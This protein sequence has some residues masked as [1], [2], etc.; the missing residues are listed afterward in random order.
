MASPSFTTTQ[1][2]TP[3]KSDNPR[4]FPQPHDDDFNTVSAT[5]SCPYGHGS[6]Q[7]KGHG[8]CSFKVQA[9]ANSSTTPGIVSSVL[10]EDNQVS[11]E[12]QKRTKFD[13]NVVVMVENNNNNNNSPP[14]QPGQPSTPVQMGIGNEEK[15]SEQEQELEYVNV[16]KT[17]QVSCLKS[18]TTQFGQTEFLN[19]ISA[20]SD[21]A[22]QILGRLVLGWL[23]RLAFPPSGTLTM[24][25]QARPFLCCVFPSLDPPIYVPKATSV[26]VVNSRVLNES[27]HGVSDT[28]RQIVS[29][30]S[31]CGG[32]LMELS[33]I[34]NVGGGVGERVLDEFMGPISEALGEAGLL[35]QNQLLSILESTNPVNHNSMREAANKTFSV[36]K[37]LSIDHRAFSERVRKFISCAA[38]FAKIEDEWKKKGEVVMWL[39]GKIENLYENEKAKFDEIAEIE[40]ETMAAIAASDKGVECIAEEVMQVREKLV[41]MEKEL[42]HRK[43]ENEE[44]KCRAGMIKEDMEEAKKKMEKARA[45]KTVHEERAAAIEALEMARLH[46]RHNH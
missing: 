36:L 40:R 8:A 14:D 45:A 5:F 21:P 35:V 15:E 2:P 9:M 19:Q 13:S 42:R 18:D 25:Q 10:N 41:G 38:E 34:K 32:I 11:F 17:L 22:K 29:R 30:D 44:L 28:Y 26:D 7:L 37:L 43:I 31:E 6:C 3:I 20:D 23:G 1:P 4:R 16:E 39:P 46:L 33:S 24:P 27:P 12:N